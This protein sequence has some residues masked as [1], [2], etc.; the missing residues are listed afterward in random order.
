MST[1]DP[2]PPV[3][4]VDFA[5]SQQ[6]IGSIRLE[7]PN[8]YLARKSNFVE[9]PARFCGCAISI[10]PS[11]L[12]EPLRRQPF[13]QQ[14]IVLAFD[15]RIAFASALL[16]SSAVEHRNVAARVTDQPRLL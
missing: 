1:L 11:F 13:G 2:E 9:Y 12:K 4:S 8:R 5:V 7:T 16:Q 15:N 3:I 10:T 14:T 6:L